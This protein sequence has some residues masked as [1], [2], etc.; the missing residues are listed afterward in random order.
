MQ[1]IDS[2]SKTWCMNSA[3]YVLLRK[4]NRFLFHIS[5][6]FNLGEDACSPHTVSHVTCNCPC[7]SLPSPE[8][9]NSDVGRQL[10][11]MNWANDDA[12]D[13]AELKAWTKDMPLPDDYVI[14]ESMFFINIMTA[15]HFVDRRICKLHYPRLVK[16]FCAL[17]DAAN[18]TLWAKRAAL[19]ATIANGEDF[20]WGKVAD[21]PQSTDWWGLRK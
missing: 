21:S 18:G 14:S 15:E 2:C 16:A 13:D 19:M 3:Q 10:L 11:L 6:L 17:K 20:G 7:C 4:E 12:D 8:S 5:I 9:A 1:L